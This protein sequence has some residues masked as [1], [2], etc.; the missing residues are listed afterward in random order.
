MLLSEVA[1]GRTLS[2]K[3]PYNG[4][5]EVKP[6][7]IILRQRD[8]VI[9]SEG[10]ELLVDVGQKE[11]VPLDVVRSPSLCHRLLRSMTGR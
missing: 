10:A 9:T 8:G 2:L 11:K 3:E 5:W 6:K 4:L 1:Q 7:A